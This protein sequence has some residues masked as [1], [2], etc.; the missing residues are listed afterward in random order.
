MV[1]FL[2]EIQASRA[3]KIPLLAAPMHFLGEFAQPLSSTLVKFALDF[4]DYPINYIFATL[5][6]F[7]SWIFNSVLKILGFISSFP[8]TVLLIFFRDSQSSSIRHKYKQ[9][10]SSSS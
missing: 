5:S 9:Q 10:F 2:H 3:E 6:R 4:L 8:Y 7:K 1:I